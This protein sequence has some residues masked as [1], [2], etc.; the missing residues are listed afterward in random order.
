V[1]YNAAELSRLIVPELWKQCRPDTL[2]EDAIRFNRDGASFDPLSRSLYSDYKTVVQYYLRR[3]GLAASQGMKP[4]FPMLDAD[5]AS[6]CAAIPSRYK[7]RG[8]SDTKYIERIAVEP[9]LPHEI[10]FRKDKLGHSI[11]LKNWLRDHEKVRGFMMD[12]LSKKRIE[13]RGLFRPAFI[14]TMIEQHLSR[15]CNH[16][17]RLWALMILDMWLEKQGVQ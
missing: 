5:V 15:R 17:H 3:M 12:R 2:F 9:L 10:V 13:S 1:Y 14:Q 6:Y 11:P 8:M 16:S 4:K 7:I